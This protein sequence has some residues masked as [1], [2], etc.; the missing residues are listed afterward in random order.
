MRYRLTNIPLWLDEDDAQI[1]ARV[2][3]R[4]RVGSEQ[5]SD[6][7]VVRRSLDARK[8]G[9][10][11]WLLNVEATIEGA[12]PALPPDVAPVAP[13]EPAP[14]RVRPPGARPI[15]LGAGPAGLTPGAL[16]AQ[17]GLAPSAL[18]FHLKELANAGLVTAE[19]NGRHLIYRPDYRRMNALLAYLTEHCCAVHPRDSAC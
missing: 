16:C 9:H 15:V 5:I 11:R 4:L 13:P 6:L 19:P 2:A 7:L 3:E 14:P 12:L 10:A 18:S 1:R 8:K 17:L